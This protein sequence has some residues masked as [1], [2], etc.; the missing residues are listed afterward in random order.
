[1][2]KAPA[3]RL[4]NQSI[5]S[6][7]TAIGPVWVAVIALY[8]ISAIISPAMFQ[9]SQVMNI[10]QVAAFV[11]LIACGQTLVLLIGGID[12]SQ[13]GVVTLINI[14]ATSMMMGSDAN[15]GF[16]VVAC[17][18]LALAIGAAN[19]FL[20]VMLRIT[21]LIATLSTNSILFGI[22]LIYTG[23][24][25]HGSSAPSFNWLGQG[26]IAGFPVS[27]LCWLAVA[28]ML[29]WV[30]RATVYGRWLYATGANPVAARMMGIPT[31]AVQASGYIVS[32][33]TAALGS[34]LLTAY[35]G[36]PSLGIGNQFMFTAVAAVV[37]GGT[38]LSGGIGGVMATVGGAIF[39][40]ELNSFTNII[41]INTGT[42]MVLQGAI[43]VASV[44]LYRA[45]AQ[46]RR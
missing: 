31:R 34:L 25:P 21:P 36:S 30:T 41:R 40:T 26:N 38:A 16:A 46:K 14:I 37:V 39:I 7:V 29:A 42:Q 45:V 4:P 10:L 33:L 19:A 35:V 20:I 15:I 11:G 27:A 8:V 28:L 3:P 6:V 22:A 2:E 23:G 44:V 43:I 24:A 18:G 13:A 9:P 12:M 32:A 1:M 17:L 5:G